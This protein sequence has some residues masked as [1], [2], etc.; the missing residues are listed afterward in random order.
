MQDPLSPLENQKPMDDPMLDALERSIE[1]TIV[2]S[3]PLMAKQDFLID[4]IA[5]QLDHVEAS[6]VN[7]PPKPLPADNIDDIIMSST[8][9]LEI[10]EIEP[11]SLNVN[12]FGQTPQDSFIPAIPQNSPARPP[13]QIGDSMGRHAQPSKQYKPLLGGRTNAQSNVSLRHCPESREIIN[14]ETCESCEKYRHWP[15]GTD[16]EP[17]ECWHD[18]HLAK[19]RKSGEYDDDN[20]E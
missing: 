2:S 15:E 6:I 7:T 18:W 14:R 5:R 20:E 10:F 19:F 1:K 16:E 11:P 4:D 8:Q 3:D 13:M 12:D 9:G 17:R